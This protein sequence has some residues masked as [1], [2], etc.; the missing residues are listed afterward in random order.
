MFIS[1]FHMLLWEKNLKVMF[2]FVVSTI[3]CVKSWDQLDYFNLFLTQSW[4][5]TNV[6]PAE[7]A[8]AT[9]VPSPDHV[10]SVPMLFPV[11]LRKMG[12]SFFH[13]IS[14]LIYFGRPP[15]CQNPKEQSNISP[16][17]F[18]ILLCTIHFIIVLELCFM[19]QRRDM[20]SFSCKVIEKSLLSTS[21]IPFPR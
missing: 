9:W 2:L 10:M 3:C 8:R 11:R 5:F 20:T 4:E 21:C 15:K 7:A 17:T 14:T 18:I 6:W 1:H 12:D 19:V 13:S 16:N